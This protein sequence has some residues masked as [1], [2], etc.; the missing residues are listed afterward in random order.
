MSVRCFF[1]SSCCL[2]PHSTHPGCCSELPNSPGWGRLPLISAPIELGGPKD[3]HLAHGKAAQ[4]PSRPPASG[5]TAH[6]FLPGLG[7]P[8]HPWVPCPRA[9]GHSDLIQRQNMRN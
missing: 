7:S 1:S 3:Q 6:L 2:C 5:F 9:R 8:S 4:H